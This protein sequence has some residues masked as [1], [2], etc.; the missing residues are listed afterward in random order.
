MARTLR[1]DFNFWKSTL[2]KLPSQSHFYPNAYQTSA[3][4]Y[5]IISSVGFD[6]SCMDSS[7]LKITKEDME[8]VL[9][10][11]EMMLDE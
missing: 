5:N 4:M 1:E 6:Q 2:S 11:L 8:K 10:I 9:S 7:C 3:K